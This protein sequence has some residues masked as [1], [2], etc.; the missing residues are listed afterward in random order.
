MKPCQIRNN[1]HR[2][3]LLVLFT[4][5]FAAIMVLP[6][7][8]QAQQA[9]EGVRDYIERTG[10]LLMWSQELVRET[11][12][13]P[14]RRV[15]TQAVELHR[16]SV[17]L[18]EGN[19]PVEALAVG[20]RARDAM[21]HSVR[22]ARE[23][24]GLEERI[25]IRVERFRDQY[26]NLL[27]RAR[28]ARD[29]QALDFLER[30]HRQ[31][32]RAQDIYRQGDFKL[33]WKLFEQANDL[34]N[35]AARLLADHSGRDRL[36]QDIDRVGDL[37][38]QSR[39]RLGSGATEQQRRILGEADESLQRAREALDQGESGRSLQMLSVAKNLA[40]RATSGDDEGPS[41]NSIQRQFDRFDGRAQ[42]IAD[43][44][45]E[46]QSEPA[47]KMYDRAVGLRERAAQA[48]QSGDNKLALRQIKSAHDLLN[49]AEKL[50]K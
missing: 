24:M 10:E 49:Q 19:K 15:L 29:K 37:I 3:P 42:R 11:E 22:V 40:R 1:Q 39:E 35:R 46:S 36:E 31:A 48:Q 20:R 27:E 18:L 16:R 41:E 21:W 50:T 8:S 28:D 34:M 9:V 14:A 5:I 12:S 23:A 4:L 30:A 6:A 47:L 2:S 7:T 33:A 38:D 44:V 17:R 26:A 13:S 45:R 43:V 25:R 32:S